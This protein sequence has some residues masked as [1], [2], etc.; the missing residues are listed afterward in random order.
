MPDRYFSLRCLPGTIAGD[1]V[2]WCWFCNGLG[3]EHER[4]CP[5][6][7]LYS[8]HLQGDPPGEPGPSLPPVPISLEAGLPCTHREGAGTVPPRSR[9]PDA[10]AGGEPSEGPSTSVSQLCPFSLGPCSWVLQSLLSED[11]APKAEPLPGLLTPSWRGTAPPAQPS[12]AQCL[13]H[14]STHI[15]V[16]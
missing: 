14:P 9:W 1:G 3:E 7:G 4:E 15:L 12:P 5:E 8:L 6:G 2:L 10:G 13:P 16:L 11:T